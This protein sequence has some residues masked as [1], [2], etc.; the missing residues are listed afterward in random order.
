MKQFRNI[1]ILFSLMLAITISCKDEEIELVPEWET[2]VHGN[3]EFLQGAAQNFV[4]GDMNVPVGTTLKWVSLDNQVTI[5][6]IDLYVLFNETYTDPSG[7]PASARH[8][9]NDGVL[10]MT[11]EGSEV[12]ANREAKTIEITQ[13]EIFDLYQNAT[14][15]YDKDDATPETPVFNNPDKPTRSE[16]SRFIKGD[17]FQLRW[18]FTADDG[19]VFDSWSPSVCNEFPDASCSINW[20]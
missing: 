1:F 2:G 13:Q 3:G 7:I 17:A 9:G 16:S 12:P 6:K 18:V 20:G 11:L 14:F 15:N 19:R 4:F 10:L 8:G 5:T